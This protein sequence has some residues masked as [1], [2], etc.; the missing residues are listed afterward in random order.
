MKKVIFKSILAGILIGI[1]AFAFSALVY[2]GQRI[3][4]SFIFSI[5][6]I[7]VFIL[8]A[9]LFTGKIGFINFKEKQNLLIILLF[10]I[11]GIGVIGLIGLAIPEIRE[12]CES[13]VC[14]KLEK[15]W[16]RVILDSIMCGAII[17]LAV[18]LY[19][20]TKSL[21]CVVLCIMAF[22]LS[23][24]EHCIA[25]VFYFIAGCKE[26]TAKAIL[27]F[28]IY[29]IGNGVGSIGVNFIYNLTLDKKD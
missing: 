21:L 3:I 5:G 12:T 18:L 4:G 2:A 1:A 28:V 17:H 23:G 13:M 10:N 8:E 25:N 7:S 22:I 24:F 6:L 14:S 16:Y 29:I 27:W 20:K 11:I 26:L 15:E 19:R 9:N